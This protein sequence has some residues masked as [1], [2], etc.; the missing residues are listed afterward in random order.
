[1]TAPG[2]AACELALAPESLDDYRTRI[3]T[4]A[5]RTAGRS[6]KLA[7]NRIIKDARG[8]RLET[9]WEFHPDAGGFWH[10]VSVRVDRQSPALHV[11]PQRRRCNLRQGSAGL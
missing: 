5:Q 1:M 9:I 4:N 6:G 7:T 2:V 3:D 8:E 10:E 11:H